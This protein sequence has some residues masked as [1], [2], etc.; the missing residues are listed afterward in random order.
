MKVFKNLKPL[1]LGTSVH[2]FSQEAQYFY[3]TNL[4]CR[5]FGGFPLLPLFFPP[6]TIC[7]PQFIL[8]EDRME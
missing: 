5:E 8:T 4:V 7:I 2:N 3:L 6:S 1:V